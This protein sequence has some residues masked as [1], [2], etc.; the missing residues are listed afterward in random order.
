MDDP[1]MIDEDEEYVIDDI[2]DDKGASLWQIIS[3]RYLKS[4]YNRL[5]GDKNAP[6]AKISE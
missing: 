1:N 3:V 4:G 6:P 2:V 5:R